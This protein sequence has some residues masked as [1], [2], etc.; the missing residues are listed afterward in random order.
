M[1]MLMDEDKNWDKFKFSPEASK[2][3]DGN[4][5]PNDVNKMVNYVAVIPGKAKIGGNGQTKERFFHSEQRIYDKYLEPMLLNYIAEKKGA[6][7]AMVLYS[8]IVPCYEQSCPSQGTTGCTSHMIQAL[9]SYAEKIEVIV[10]YTTKGGG[11]SGSTKCNAKKTEKQLKAAGI[12]VLKI[13]Y[14]SEEEA[15]IEDLIKI[16]RLLETLE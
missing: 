14:N 10:A 12:D 3:A 8:W 6:P 13:K 11:M 2:T 16:S 4:V 15:I 5:Q 9:K 7:K 1:L